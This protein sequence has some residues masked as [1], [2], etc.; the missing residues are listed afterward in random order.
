MEV[1]CTTIE[2]EQHDPGMDVACIKAQSACFDIMEEHG[3]NSDWAKYT[4][5]FKKVIATSDKWIYTFEFCAE[6][7]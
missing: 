1:T 5:E 2:I 7:W 6:N 4:I 3:L